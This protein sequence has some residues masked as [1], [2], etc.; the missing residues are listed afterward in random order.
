MWYYFLIWSCSYLLFD[1]HPILHTLHAYGT[2]PSPHPP[3]PP[4]LDMFIIFLKG[5]NKSE[6]ISVECGKKIVGRRAE[7]SGETWNELSS[8][9]P[10]ESEQ[11]LQVGFV[12]WE[13]DAICLKLVSSDE[14]VGVK[15]TTLK[16][17]SAWGY[18]K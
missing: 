7:E 8:G 17:W 11:V 2:P 6:V 10:E 12:G 3:T 1:E 5:F 4:E 13:W 16:E 14:G 15:N 18:V 9:E